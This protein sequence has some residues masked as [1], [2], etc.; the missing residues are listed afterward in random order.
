VDHRLEQVPVVVD[1]AARLADEVTG[2]YVGGSVAS[3]DYRPGVSDIDAVALVERTPGA[4]LRRTI[5]AH[6]RRLGVTALHCVYVPRSRAVDPTVKHWTWAFD[7]LFQRP[8]G[9]IARAEL[10]A[11]PVVV[12]G[13]AP[14]TWL[15]PMTPDAVRVAAVAD[16]SGYWRT[17]L[18]K[19]RIW[20]EDVYVDQAVTAVARADITVEQGRLA[21]KSAAIAHL[22]ALG[23]REDIVAGV[24]RRRAGED[25]SMTPAE[26]SERGATVRRFV[27]YHLDR[28]DELVGAS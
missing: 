17:A 2:L 10:L 8:L 20:H 19:K 13:P 6:H 25:T 18:R 1:L 24:L 7:E 4:P 26:R 15:P 27:A 23:L 9:G 11:H 21:T 28:L 3:G 5:A 12:H 16:L 14:A 22:P